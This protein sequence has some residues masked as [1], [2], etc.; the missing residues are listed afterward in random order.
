MRIGLIDV[1][2]H[3]FPNLPLMKLSAYHKQHGD[4]VEWYEPLFHS[5]GEP[6]DK[7][8]MSKVFSFTPDYQYYVN[9]REVEK[10]GSGY[11]I[12]LIDGKETWI[13]ENA[14]FLPSEIEHIYPDYSL[15]PELTENS[16]FGFLTRGCPCDCSF[17]HV[18]DKE[19]KCSVKVANL[20]EF[21][22]GQKNIVLLD[23]NITACKDWKDLFQQLIDSN[24]WVDFTQGLR[25]HMMTEEKAEMIKQMK[26]NNVHFAWDKYS[27]KDIVIPKFKQFKD[28]TGYG[29]QKLTVYMLTNFD[30]TIDEDLERVYTLRELGYN[31]YVMIYNKD[32]F[33]ITDCNGK[34]TKR[35]PKRELLKEYTEEQIDHFDKCWDLQGWVNNRIIFRSCMR[36]ED[37][38]RVAKED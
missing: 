29:Y 17:C 36:F 18:C 28:I 7:V 12:K 3:N 14:T 6:F 5:M 33:V 13:K 16:A 25:I 20:S 30:T 8:Y 35:K 26:I 31:P 23:P 11:C 19:G 27:D 9:A 21:W 34:P 32:D 10:G 37:Y 22:R 24:S 1:D 38:K 2:G 15:Y 4:T